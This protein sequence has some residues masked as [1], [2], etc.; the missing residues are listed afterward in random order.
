MAQETIVRALIGVLCG[1]ALLLILLIIGGSGIDDTT[2]R[3][4][5]VAAAVAFFSLTGLAGSNLAQRRPQF[6]AVGYVTMAV[7]A[8][9]LLLW[10]VW[11]LGDPGGDAWRP[12]A[13]AG[14]LA[15]ALGHTSALLA[16]AR[17]QD[18]DAI[19]LV[20]GGTIL[21]LAVLVALAFV[22]IAESG[23]DV[24]RQAM[25]IVAV[26]YVL[27]VVLL[28]LLRRTSGGGGVAPP[29]VAE[30]LSLDHVGVAGANWE[31]TGRFYTEV[32]GIPAR[33]AETGLCFAWDGT[34]AEAIE[35]LHR[36]GVE[37]EGPPISRIGARGEGSAIR[38]R[39]PAGRLIELISYS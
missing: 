3:A 13:Y 39:D 21:A 35:H 14:I 17:E 6:L 5:G 38:F 12:G 32:L 37:V 28:P 7:S 30:T 2:G 33:P 20:R 34:E 26:L 36:H 15:F 31:R 29:A 8:V 24:N 22:E 25:A 10:V 23:P 11:L 4:I 16:A 19:E 9:A 1:A 18:S 27:G